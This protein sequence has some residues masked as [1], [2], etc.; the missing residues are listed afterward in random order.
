MKGRFAARFGDA[1]SNR[2]IRQQTKRPTIPSRRWFAASQCNHMRLGFAI[3]C[4]GP[5]AS[6]IAMF[7]RQLQATLNQ[8]LAKS[9]D[10]HRRDVESFGYASVDPARS[11]F[12]LVGLEQHPG[13]TSL[14]GC[15]T[16][17]ADDVF[18]LATFL[19]CQFYNVLFHGWPPYRE[20]G[21][22]KPYRQEG[23]IIS[24]DGTEY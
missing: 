11:V 16:I 5:A 1:Q 22:M 18:E 14:V 8:A 23:L 20:K 15:H 3:Q 2:L 19:S 10:A 13:M 9:L 17:R 6:A 21:Y 12:A 4:L 7:Q 24:I